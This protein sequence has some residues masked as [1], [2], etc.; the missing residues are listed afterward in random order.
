M[1]GDICWECEE[2]VELINGAEHL[3]CV[4]LALGGIAAAEALW[5]RVWSAVCDG[6]DGAIRE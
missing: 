3:G 5:W 1:R 4:Q 2:F 6:F